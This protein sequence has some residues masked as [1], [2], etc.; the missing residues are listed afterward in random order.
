[1][2]RW[3]AHRVFIR[4]FVGGFTASITL[5]VIAITA[6]ILTPGGQSFLRDTAEGSA[7]YIETPIVTAIT[8][9][10]FYCLNPLAIAAA[11]V[12]PRISPLKYLSSVAQGASFLVGLIVS[13]ATWWIFV[14]ITAERA[15]VRKSRTIQ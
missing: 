14:A 2:T 4:T 9:I 12:I 6:A 11:Y 15:S 13:S 7:L 1:M 10:A 3:L 5:L 8:G